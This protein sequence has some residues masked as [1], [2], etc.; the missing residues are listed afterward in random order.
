M[1]GGLFRIEADGVGDGS[2]NGE[3]LWVFRRVVG[4]TI[5]LTMYAAASRVIVYLL[6]FLHFCRVLKLLRRNMRHKIP[7]RLLGM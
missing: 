3:R 4:K 6:A 7:E 1:Y 5:C 2:I